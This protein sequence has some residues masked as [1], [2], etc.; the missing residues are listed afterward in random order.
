MAK[1]IHDN[2]SITIDARGNFVSSDDNTLTT[3]SGV[4]AAHVKNTHTVNATTETS[5]ADGATLLAGETEK[6]KGKYELSLDQAGK[7]S[8]DYRGGSIVIGS[9]NDAK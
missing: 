4:G 3:G 8:H 5:V 1:T 9:R 7:S 2:K 6:T